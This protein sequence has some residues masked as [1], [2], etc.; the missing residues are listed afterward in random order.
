MSE[1][2]KRAAGARKGTGGLDRILALLAFLLL[3]AFLAVVVVFV[4]EVDLTIVML[5][6]LL[7]AWAE[8]W[9]LIRGRNNGRPR[10]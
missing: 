5:L 10:P 1:T 8:L 3:I 6:V 2:P 7:M 9:P 4:G